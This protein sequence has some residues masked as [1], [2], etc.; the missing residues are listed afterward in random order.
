MSC[1]SQTGRT[2]VI[3][4]ETGEIPCKDACLVSKSGSELWAT[5]TF[6]SGLQWRLQV[7]DLILDYTILDTSLSGLYR[8]FTSL[9]QWPANLDMNNYMKLDC[10]DY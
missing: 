1:P 7:P 5:P 3:K 4:D 10:S 2:V 6:F 8:W 9:D